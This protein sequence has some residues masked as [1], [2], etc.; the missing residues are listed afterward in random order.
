[1]RRVAFLTLDDPTGFVIDDDRAVAP[2]AALGWAV[3][4][5]SWRADADWGAFEA[6]VIRSPWDYSEAPE[7]FLAVLKRIDASPALLLNGLRAVRW[8]LRKTYLREMEAAGVPTIPTVWRDSLGPGEAAGLFD[9]V[10]AGEIVVKPVVGANA[11]GAFRITREAPRSANA[12]RAVEAH[13]AELPLM[14]QPFV[15]AVVAEGEFSVFA[16]GG[17][18]SHTILKTP[19][20]CDFRVQ[21]EHGGIITAVDPEPALLA[22]AQRAFDATAAAV[23]EPLL[24]ARAD[25]VRAPGGAFWLMEVE[26]VEPALYFRMDA[27][28]PRRFAEAFAARMG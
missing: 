26:V 4:T 2:L 15:P 22:A 7:A 27:G 13:Y 3:E 9:T 24:Y 21:E 25:L 6:V 17:E 1:V 20:P 23:R 8:N 10:G 14:A 5:V 11:S 18:V 28:A 12:H 16:F 19:A